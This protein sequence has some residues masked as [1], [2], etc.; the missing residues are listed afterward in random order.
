MKKNNY[1]YLLIIFIFLFCNTLVTNS[2]SISAAETASTPT[3]NYE[4]IYKK[5]F[6]HAPP[7]ITKKISAIL[8]TDNFNKT[9]INILITTHNDKVFLN[10]KTLIQ[11]LSKTLKN[12]NQLKLEEL[13]NSKGY[14]LM[15]D[16]K[17]KKIKA[18]YDRNNTIVYIETNPSKR[19]KTIISFKSSYNNINQN[20]IPPCPLSGF[21]NIY[22]SALINDNSGQQLYFP[23]VDLFG[24]L[25]VEGWV[26]NADGKYTES[27]T[28]YGYN[29]SDLYF[30]N[31]QIRRDFPQKELRLNLAKL[32]YPFN[33]FFT[34]RSLFGIGLTKEQSYK[35][36]Y[37][38]CPEYEYEI[39]LEQPSKIKIEINGKEKYSRKLL[40]Y[41]NKY[42]PAGKYIFKDFPLD[43]GYNIVDFEFK[44]KQGNKITDSLIYIK[45]REFLSPSQEEYSVNIGYP[46][47]YNFN[48]NIYDTYTELPSIAL[49]YKTGLSEFFTLQG[50]YQQD[51]NLSVIGLENI[52]GTFNGPLIFNLSRSTY[53]NISDYSYMLKFKNYINY[54]PPNKFFNL[55][56]FSLEAG[57]LGENFTNFSYLY[58]YAI[59]EPAFT[60][61][62]YFNFS[63]LNSLYCILSNNQISTEKS[64]RSIFSFI[65]RKRIG[66]IDV[67]AY[68]QSSQGNYYNNNQAPW[69]LNFRLS[70][71][72]S[73]IPY[74]MDIDYDSVAQTSKTN[75]RYG[76]AYISNPKPGLD[77]G[78]NL[79][80][81]PTNP[82]IGGFA[83]Y[84]KDTLNTKVGIDHYSKTQQQK[85]YAEAYSINQFGDYRVNH[86]QW[87]NEE[88]RARTTA[89]F[90]TALVYADG[91]FG[92]SAPVRDSFVLFYPHPDTKDLPILL[93]SGQKNTWLSPP[94]VTNLQNFRQNTLRINTD[95][96]PI[97]YDIGGGE[98]NIYPTYGSGF[99]IRVGEG[100]TVFAMGQLLNEY[101][102]PISYITGELIS[103]DKPNTEPKMFFTN[104]DGEFQLQGILPGEYKLELYDDNFSSINFFIPK[105]Q[106]GAIVYIGKLIIAQQ[107][108]QIKKETKITQENEIENLL[109][110]NSVNVLSKLE[111]SFS[112]I[113]LKTKNKIKAKNLCKTLDKLKIVYIKN[114][115]QSIDGET[116]VVDL[117]QYYSFEKA[118]NTQKKANK[119][120]ISSQIFATYYDACLGKFSN[121]S[122]AEKIKV[123]LQKKG[124]PSNIIRL[125]DNNKEY[126]TV[127][128][129]K[130]KSVVKANNMLSSFEELHIDTFLYENP[131]QL[132]VG[133]FKSLEKAKRLDELLIEKKDIFTKL[134]KTTR[135]GKTFYLVSAGEYTNHKLIIKTVQNLQK[136]GIPVYISNNQQ[137]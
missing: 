86:S 121:P 123:V 94:V 39:E 50:N 91:Y 117:G 84:S 75:I 102:K 35:A 88:A 73:F 57:Y 11:E 90:R 78:A 111:P 33:S 108:N 89:H 92:I 127:V 64:T 2:N 97:G 10:A 95:E 70:W 124:I 103:L 38:Q 4:E 59:N 15:Q 109:L 114:K 126:Y 106:P 133:A 98:Y 125:K 130:F 72:P 134:D 43:Y 23:S 49:T 31:F 51:P 24:N 29:S 69:S 34:N 30:N 45:S 80:I 21:L 67:S 52:L 41:K 76:Q 47:I 66:D 113:A 5:V 81:D 112:L 100:A 55:S 7:K 17:S 82:V 6:G 63:F 79:N 48:E 26:L 105:G 18:S 77:F 12:I 99:A 60:T 107:Q 40:K 62:V 120:G 93:N 27:K 131:Y 87:L 44:D 85:L 25:Y 128:I 20:L 119:K 74:N 8:S 116:Q 54:L 137:P 136:Q 1:K 9:P 135:N 3:K 132:I 71:Q 53:Q 83:N 61:G 19:K 28:N 122:I 37:N 129:N 22:S 110:P 115:F 16:L 68:Y 118:L 13:I 56:S 101:Q 36:Y 58:N 14:I 32:D 65:V 42:I 96:I 46:Y 104:R